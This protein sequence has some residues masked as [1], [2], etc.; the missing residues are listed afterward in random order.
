MC[1]FYLVVTLYNNPLVK[2]NE[3][4]SQFASKAASE[5]A[6]IHVPVEM[7]Y[8][9]PVNGSGALDTKSGEV[10][11]CV[12]SPFCKQVN[13]SHLHRTIYLIVFT[14]FICMF[15][16]ERKLTSSAVSWSMFSFL[17]RNNSIAT[18]VT[19]WEKNVHYYHVHY[20]WVF[21]CNVFL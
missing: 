16:F 8:D 3:M 20:V 19:Q 7:V 15:C 2:L 11:S 6:V 17:F 12:L 13:L 10:T 9:K 21:G 5:I 1:F 14:H 18:S 4:C